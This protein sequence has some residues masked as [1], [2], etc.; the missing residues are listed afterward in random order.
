MSSSK[1]RRTRNDGLSNSVNIISLDEDYD[2]VETRATGYGQNYWDE[3]KARVCSMWELLS[4]QRN[5]LFD[6]SSHGF[7]FSDIPIYNPDAADDD[8]WNGDAPIPI[9]EEG[10]MNSHAGG[11]YNFHTFLSTLLADAPSRIDMRD[12]HYRTED[13]NESWER[14]LPRLVDAY[15]DHQVH[16][17]PDSADD[18]QCEGEPWDITCMDFYAYELIQNMCHVREALTTNKSLARYGLLSGSPDNPSVAFSFKFL[19]CFCQIHRVCPRFSMSGLSRMLTNIH[20]LFPKPHLEQQLRIAYDA[21]LAI[22]REVQ[23]RLDKALGRDTHEYFVRNVCPPCTYRLEHEV[24]LK[25]TILMA[26]DGNNSLKLVD[27]D[28]RYGRAR[29]DTRRLKHPR[30]LDAEFVDQYKDEVANAQHKKPTKPNADF[31]SPCDQPDSEGNPVTWV[32]DD[33]LDDLFDKLSPCVEQWKAAGPEANK[34]MFSFFSIS[35]IFVSVCRHGHVLVICDMRRSGE[36]MKYP[37]AIVKA[38][39]D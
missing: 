13:Q 3:A 30:W 7:R 20:G 6:S 4:Y 25:P 19:E 11:E 39:L 24:E 34:K 2:I 36:L 38:L 32:N 14:Q 17:P 8:D 12:R 23:L 31:G 18:D 28:K 27:T 5:N 22:Q 33:E 10:A 37:L 35:G 21:Y 16:G 26:M 15:L 29:L 1:R 9:G